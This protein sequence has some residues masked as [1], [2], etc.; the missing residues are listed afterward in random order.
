[1]KHSS[2]IRRMLANTTM[3][4]AFP[5]SF[6]ETLSRQDAADLFRVYGDFINY[7]H[8]QGRYA[9]EVALHT[10]SVL[11][12]IVHIY[13]TTEDAVDGWDNISHKVAALYNAINQ[14]KAKTTDADEID[15][16]NKFY[17][18]ISDFYGPLF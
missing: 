7:S 2:T 12:C 3:P 18:L 14:R 11:G 16:L 6:F 9:P 10:F 17:H 4:L 1:M 15:N 5:K 13:N 8:K